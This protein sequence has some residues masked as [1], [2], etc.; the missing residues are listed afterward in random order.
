MKKYI[1][2]YKKT[3]NNLTKKLYFCFRFQFLHASLNLFTFWDHDL[4]PLESRDVIVII[5][6]MWFGN[7]PSISHGCCD[8]KVSDKT[9][10]QPKA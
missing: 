1:V 7:H 9:T 4:D 6:Y 3:L 10:E 2:E 5:C 8:I